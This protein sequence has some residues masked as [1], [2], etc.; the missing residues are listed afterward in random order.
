MDLIKRED[1][2]KDFD[3]SDPAQF[4]KAC[5]VLLDEKK[6]KNIVIINLEGKS[7]V[8]DYFVICSASSTPQVRALAEHVD[9]EMGKHGHNITHRD[10]DTK[11]SALDYGDVIVH[12]FHTDVRDYY[13]LEHLWDD[14]K[15]VEYFYDEDAPKS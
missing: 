1:L 7:V 8:A 9:D 12:V 3:L 2:I 6:G 15:N 14:G 10:I 5:A 13:Q 4:A 11:W